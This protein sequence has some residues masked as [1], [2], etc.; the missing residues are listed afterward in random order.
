MSS[1]LWT[2]FTMN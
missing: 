1:L 2:N